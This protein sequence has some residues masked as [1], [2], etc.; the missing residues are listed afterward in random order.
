ME[1]AQETYNRREE[2]VSQNDKEGAKK[3]ACACG[4]DTHEVMVAL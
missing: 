1:T 2:V 4:K 3:E